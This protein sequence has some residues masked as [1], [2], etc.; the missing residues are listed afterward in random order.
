MAV[1][2]PQFT[3]G[4]GGP[5]LTN[6][7]FDVSIQPGWVTTAQ[8]AMRFLLAGTITVAFIIAFVSLYNWL[9]SDGNEIKVYENKERLGKMMIVMTLCFVLMALYRLWVP[10]YAAL[11]L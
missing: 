4:Q 9:Y 10:D 8:I 2:V 3:L 5:A 6:S 1:T 11:S 7:A